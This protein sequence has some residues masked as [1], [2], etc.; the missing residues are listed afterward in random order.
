MTTQVQKP[1]VQG[2]DFEVTGI[3][4]I[5][6]GDLDTLSN[7]DFQT[8]KPR[9]NA[10][11]S[12]KK[13]ENFYAL[14]FPKMINNQANPD[15]ARVQQYLTNIARRDW[16]TFFPNNSPTCVN[17]N[18]HFKITDGD[19]YDKSGVHNAT[20]EGFAGHWVLRFSS[21]FLPKRFYQGQT[22]VDQEITQPGVIKRGDFV[23]VVFTAAGNGSTQSP[24]LFVRGSAVELFYAGKA[25]VSAASGPD[26]AA[27]LASGPAVN[28]VPEGATA[29]QAPGNAMPATPAPASAPVQAPASAPVQA[30][31]VPG[32]QPEPYAGY[33]PTPV[34]APAVPVAPVWPPAGWTQHPDNPD[35]W[36]MGS[37]VI[38][39]ATL[40]AR[41]Q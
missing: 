7:L 17:P 28:Y 18:F 40:R 15:W 20:K 19:G 37:E 10:D 8:G 9:V 21:Q 6:Q 39:E 41:Q 27:A 24:G 12:E 38:T 11:G 16:P 35:Y 32:A 29:V 22:R 36:Y 5:V 34:A 4:R 1:Q 3:G 30:P 25:I 26:A 14:A 2:V 23:R 31:A 13:P 33:I